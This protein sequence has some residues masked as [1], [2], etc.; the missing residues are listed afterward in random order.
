MKT[1][2]LSTHQ[3]VCFPVIGSWT[4]LNIGTTKVIDYQYSTISLKD[5]TEFSP[6]VVIFI[7]GL[8][9]APKKE[10]LL[11][12]RKHAPL[13]QLLFDGGD[14]GWHEKLLSWQDCFSVIVNVDGSPKWPSRKEDLTLLAPI[15]PRPFDISPDTQ[16]NVLLGFPGAIG[17]GRRGQLLD[18]LR[19]S[20]Y[21]THYH[22]PGTLDEV[23]SHDKVCSYDKYI[24]FLKRCRFIINNSMSANGESHV[25][26]RV[27]ETGLAKA[28]LLE[29]KNSVTGQWFT[30]G[31]HYLE[32]TTPEEVIDI[33][34]RVGEDESNRIAQNLHNEIK[35]KYSPEIFWKKVMQSVD[36]KI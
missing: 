19:S 2:I 4:Y 18:F 26:F 23:C 5:I 6:D 11:A 30:P 25:K 27:T 36:I 8:E 35:K 22:R 13:I 29:D 15:D 21:M 3:G 33:V 32:Y 16:R 9:C 12:I 31:E 7:A 34:R 17:S 28:C 10:S 14:I 20:G 24:E 1:V